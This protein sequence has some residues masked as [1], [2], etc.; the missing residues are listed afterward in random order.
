MESITVREVR[1]EYGA[2]VALDDVSLSVDRGS[3]HLLAGPN[4]SGKSTL[5]GLLLGLETPTAGTVDVPDVSLGPGFQRPT[6][7]PDLAVATNLDV[8]G[9]LVNADD[10]WREAL[11]AEL[12]LDRVQ[13]REAAALSGGYAKK[14]DLAL[15]LLGRPEV[16]L[17]DEPL[18]DLDDVTRDAV[19][20]LLGRYRDDG[21]TVLVSTHRLEAFGAAA[22]AV[23]VLDRG[24]VVFDAAGDDL[25]AAVASAGSV[26]GLYAD[27]LSAEAPPTEAPAAKRPDV[28]D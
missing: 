28:T 14:L 23:T 3:F 2:V 27:V 22:D 11:E 5:L 26:D 12:G 4:G 13:H 18:G 21:G 17:L 20:D 25:D 1:K 15:A 16:V 10:A 8:F 19:V 9:A 7:Y 24:E 6:F